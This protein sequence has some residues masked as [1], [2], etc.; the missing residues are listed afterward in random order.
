MGTDSGFEYNYKSAHR[1][2]KRTK[3]QKKSMGQLADK[4]ILYNNWY[5]FMLFD[6]FFLLVQTVRLGNNFKRSYIV[7]NFCI[8]NC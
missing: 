4:L 1:S 2:I 6:F 7:L 3:S 5:Y 8:A